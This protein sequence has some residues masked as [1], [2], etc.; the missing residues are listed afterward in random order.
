ML[1]AR[2]KAWI[3]SSLAGR[4]KLAAECERLK[5]ARGVRW[6]DLRC[7]RSRRSRWVVSLDGYLGIMG[8]EWFDVRFIEVLQVNVGGS[9]SAK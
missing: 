1:A 6:L 2:S 7:R 5:R 8:L 4:K 3:A 9:M